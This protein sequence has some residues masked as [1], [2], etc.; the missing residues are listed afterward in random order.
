ME[1]RLVTINLALTI[2]IPSDDDFFTENSAS[3]S[4]YLNGSNGLY[5]QI[6]KIDG[7]KTV[8]DVSYEFD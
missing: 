6:G 8:H 7:V 2:E 3:D 4:Q 5:A 1:N